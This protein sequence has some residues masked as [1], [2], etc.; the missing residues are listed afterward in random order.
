M[1][2]ASV[3][4][5]SLPWAAAA[6]A[7]GAAGRVPLPPGVTSLSSRR[8]AGV[9][10]GWRVSEGGMRVAASGDGEQDRLDNLDRRVT[11]AS[12]LAS[13]SPHAH[14]PPPSPPLAF[15]LLRLLLLTAD[16]NSSTSSSF[17][18][19]FISSSCSSWSSWSSSSST[20]PFRSFRS[21]RVWMR[22]FLGRLLTCFTAPF[23]AQTGRSGSKN[24]RG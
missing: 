6:R 13:P 14:H 7:K 8:L 20:F 9:A 4:C 3:C 5:A 12:P 10:Q 23:H 24:G 21:F 17:T 2:S 19:S 18:F 16:S 15:I 1:A 11:V 22:D